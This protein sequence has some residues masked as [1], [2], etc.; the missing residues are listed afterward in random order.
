MCDAR[1]DGDDQVHRGCQSGSSVEIITCIEMHKPRSVW[2]GA[3]LF[4]SIAFLQRKPCDP[5][6]IEQ[7]SKER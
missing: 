5:V 1:I 7:R 2:Y 3:D 6:H 4:L